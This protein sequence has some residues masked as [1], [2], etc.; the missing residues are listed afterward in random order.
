MSASIG[1]LSLLSNATVGLMGGTYGV[2][3]AGTATVN[4][5]VDSNPVSI[6]ALTLTAGADYTLLIWSDANGIESTLISDDNHIPTTS[7]D[8]KLRLL[9][10]MSGLGSTITLNADFSPV[11]QET[12]VGQASAA[13]QID[14]GADYELDVTNSSTGA[15]LFS[16]TSVSLVSGNV[17][18]LFMSG[19]GTAPVNGTLKKDR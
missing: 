9:N 8:V 6:P 14:A 3:N 5:T 17:Y 1:D 11:A 10:G 13:A 7:G 19:G 4:L 18:T 2:L 15:A 16:K 12:A